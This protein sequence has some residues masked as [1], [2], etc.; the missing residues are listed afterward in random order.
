[1]TGDGGQSDFSLLD[2]FR[3]EIETHL[4]VLS[5]GLLALEKDA[6]DKKRL[7]AL[8]RAA[9][10]IKGAAR[11]VGV[12][13][14]VQVAHV[15]EDCFVAAQAGR[16]TLDGDAT[17]VLLRGV[18]TLGQIGQ[19]SGQQLEAWLTANQS[20]FKALLDE[21]AAVKTSDAARRPRAA[22][23][24]APPTVPVTGEG[25]WKTILAPEVLDAPAAEE[26]RLIL[27]SLLAQGAS[28]FRFDLARVRDVQPKGLALLDLFART[29]RGRELP[30]TL[31]VA[32]ASP[33]LVT[34][35]RM[36]RLDRS[37]TF[38]AAGGN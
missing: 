14:A 10:S 3:A 32:N 25:P 1:V 36:T 9:H 38:A 15:M 20:P 16:I 29:V 22:V 11:I 35:F 12:E 18:D 33:D 24:P 37:Y 26:L 8:M 13:A 34:L 2:L 28:Q 27:T 7:E 30:A 4:P 19:S 17:D 23:A 5:E 21:L 6:G 31:E